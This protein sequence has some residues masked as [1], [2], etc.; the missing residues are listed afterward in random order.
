MPDQVLLGI[1]ISGYA[2][3]FVV[4]VNSMA[5]TI[6]DVSQEAHLRQAM[7]ITHVASRL[8]IARLDRIEKLAEMSRRIRDRRFRPWKVID[9]FP[10][11]INLVLLV[12]GYQRSFCSLEESA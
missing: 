4:P 10:L 1:L 6:G 9:L 5:G 3:S 2:L 12:V 7:T 8:Q 11:H